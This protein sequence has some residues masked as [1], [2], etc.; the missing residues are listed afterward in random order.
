MRLP[1][2]SCNKLYGET[3]ADKEGWLFKNYKNKE[4][5]NLVEFRQI[6]HSPKR[7]FAPLLDLQHRQHFRG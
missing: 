1:R 5:E 7:T 4:G 6:I 2:V 3:V